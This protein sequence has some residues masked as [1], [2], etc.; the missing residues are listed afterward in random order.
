MVAVM[1]DLLVAETVDQLD[2]LMVVKL[3]DRMELMSADR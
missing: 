2:I 1:V 3:V